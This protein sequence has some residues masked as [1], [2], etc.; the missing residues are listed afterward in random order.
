MGQ[1]KINNPEIKFKKQILKGME[2]YIDG[3]Y[4]EYLLNY[5]DITG[6]RKEELERFIDFVKGEIKLTKLLISKLK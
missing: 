6:V 5:G 3:I 1:Q 2:K 4:E